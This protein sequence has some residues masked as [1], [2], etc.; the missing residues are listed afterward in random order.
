MHHLVVH[1]PFGRFRRGEH[2]TDPA[3][4]AS[5]LASE[6]AGH[7]RRIEAD[8]PKVEPSAEPPILAEDHPAEPAEHEGI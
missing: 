4:I 1:N 6:N 3:E 2:I 5:V 8:E 7:A